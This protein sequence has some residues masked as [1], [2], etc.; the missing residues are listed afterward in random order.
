M[1]THKELIDNEK[2]KVTE[3]IKTSVAAGVHAA[4]GGRH[5]DVLAFFIPNEMLL[6]A[7]AEL[8]TFVDS[9][10]QKYAND[11][12]ILSSVSGAD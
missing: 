9:W 11:P 8:S 3:T 2:S 5:Q 6:K 12:T 4:I 1:S 7:K 10:V